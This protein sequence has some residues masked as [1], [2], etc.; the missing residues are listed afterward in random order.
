MKKLATPSAPPVSPTANDLRGLG[1]LAV[2]GVTGVTNL[3]EAMHAAI[4]HLPAVI[5]RPAPA[6]TSGL[7]G[8]VYRGVRGVTQLVGTG[9][10]RSLSGLAPLLGGDEPSPQREAIRAAVNGVLGDHLESSANP[11]AIAMQFRSQGQP[12]ALSPRA[13]TASLPDATGKLLVLV[14]GL[15]MNDLQWNYA[16][17]DHGQALQQD[18]GYTPVYLHYNSG[19]RISHNGLE[20]AGLLEQLVR[21]YPVP[22][23]EITLLCHSMGGLVAR[24][25]LDQ[26]LASSHAWA[27]LPTRVLFLGTPH[28]GAPLERAG[29]WADMLI[30]ISPYSAP[31]VRIGKIRSAGI[32]DLRHGNLRD[33][34]WQ[35]R[36]GDDRADG[37]TPMPLPASV[38]AYAMAVSTQE[39]REDRDIHSIRGDGLVPVASALGVHADRAFD[40]R[41]PKPRRWVGHEANH[42]EL[43]GSQAVYRQM[44]RWLR[45]PAAPAVKE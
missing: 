41:I 4:T 44:L 34:D 28:H 22:V 14:H 30:G 12:L 21:A 31:L 11:L 27:G 26:A 36:N 24:A 29:S 39:A 18:L 2:D 9:V 20:L 3:V 6:T 23:E 25:A 43:L 8:L 32:Q 5:G 45:K 37:R 16:G 10:D 40:L 13:L 15:C 35:D 7:T 42:L 1:R 38:L 19:R 17:H 33:A